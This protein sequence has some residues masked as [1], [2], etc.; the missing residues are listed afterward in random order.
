MSE[1]DSPVPYEETVKPTKKE[2]K[3]KLPT[4]KAWTEMVNKWLSLNNPE[5]DP[6]ELLRL[7]KATQQYN[8]PNKTPEE[9]EKA[10]VVQAIR[11]ERLRRQG[12]NPTDWAYHHSTQPSNFGSEYS[13]K[14]MEA[15]FTEED[16]ASTAARFPKDI[17]FFVMQGGIS[18]GSEY[19][20]E[21]NPFKEIDHTWEIYVRVK[22]EQIEGSSPQIV[23]PHPQIEG[24][25]STE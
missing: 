22:P 25:T 23:S 5:G 17:D 20:K 8:N 21:E 1:E 18:S 3:E 19:V 13:G 9:R 2:R 6:E 11:E 16:M 14:S 7:T 24:P 10:K 15:P 4:K 12:L